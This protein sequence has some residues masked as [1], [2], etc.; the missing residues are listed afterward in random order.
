MSQS[1]IPD[2]HS[3]YSDNSDLSIKEISVDELFAVGD[4]NKVKLLIVLGIVYP[5]CNPHHEL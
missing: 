4:Q 2:Q 5:T 3:S 1:V